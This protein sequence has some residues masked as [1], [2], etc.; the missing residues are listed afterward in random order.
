MVGVP[1]SCYQFKPANRGQYLPGMEYETSSRS[2]SAENELVL[3]SDEGGVGI[4]AVEQVSGSTN[5]IKDNF[6]ARVRIN[7]LSNNKPLL[8]CVDR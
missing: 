1:P 3:L 6:K 8:Y 5:E 7:G 4:L 2:F